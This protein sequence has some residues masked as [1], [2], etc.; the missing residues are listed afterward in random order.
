MRIAKHLLRS[1][2]FFREHCLM[3]R[4]LLFC[5]LKSSQTRLW[6]GHFQTCSL[7]DLDCFLLGLLHLLFLFRKNTNA[8]LPIQVLN[9]WAS[10]HWDAVLEGLEYGR[11][12]CI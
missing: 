9:T 11:H 7:S 4:F 5:A 1:V 3:L 8:C 12:Y 6:S 2:R 10:L